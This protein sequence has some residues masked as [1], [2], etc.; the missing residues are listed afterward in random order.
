MNRDDGPARKLESSYGLLLTV[1]WD[2]R[3]YD[4][5]E[6]DK[7]AGNRQV[8]PRA[9]LKHDAVEYVEKVIDFFAVKVRR[10]WNPKFVSVD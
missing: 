4:R 7:S 2:E 1:E 3:N 9:D 6:L 8:K 10:I 5:D